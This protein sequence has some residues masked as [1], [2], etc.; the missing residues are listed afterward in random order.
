MTCPSSATPERQTRWTEQIL[1]RSAWTRLTLTVLTAVCLSGCEGPT[2]G[3]PPTTLPSPPVRV[4]LFSEELAFSAAPFGAVTYLFRDVQVPRSGRV[5]ITLDWTFESSNLD[6]LVTDS[7]CEDSTLLAGACSISASDRTQAK[8]AGLTFTQPAA[9][10]IRV[11]ILSNANV[12]EA[13]VLN[14]YLTS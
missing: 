6:I 5:E 4:L 9:A 1:G 7:A 3:P 11:W 12:D 8:P 2:S 13:G 14:V 10:T